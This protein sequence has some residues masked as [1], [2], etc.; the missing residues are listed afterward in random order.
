MNACLAFRVGLL[1]IISLLFTPL[2]ARAK[3]F[4]LITYGDTIG[5]LGDVSPQP[6]ETPSRVTVGIKSS[7][8]G[9][10]WIDLWTWGG[11]FCLYK[12]NHYQPIDHATVV[13]LLGKP[14]SEVREPFLYR[15]PLGRLILAVLL[16]VLGGLAIVGSILPQSR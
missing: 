4:Y 8:A 15:F 12:D 2:E 11:Q 5:H 10:F 13:Q 3:G 9:I 7:Y 6:G 14:E 16:A 1:L